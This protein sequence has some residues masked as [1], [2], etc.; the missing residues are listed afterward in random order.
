MWLGL[1]TATLYTKLKNFSV[2]IKSKSKQIEDFV[3][4]GSNNQVMAEYSIKDL[5][6]L[7]GVKAHTIRIWEQRYNLLNPKRT[8]TNIRYYLTKT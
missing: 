2:K 5:E 4:L 1:P 3:C 6:T 7:S 8:E